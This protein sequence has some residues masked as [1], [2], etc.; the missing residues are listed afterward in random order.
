M[1]CAHSALETEATEGGLKF[2]VGLMMNCSCLEVL[3][4]CL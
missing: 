2:L 1:L 4:C 3:G